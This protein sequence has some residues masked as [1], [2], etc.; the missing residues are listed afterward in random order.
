MGPGT[1]F[2][3]GS[4]DS[5]ASSL[6]CDVMV[7]MFVC[8]WDQLL[9]LC[10]RRLPCTC[11]VLRRSQ[12]RLPL[13]VGEHRIVLFADVHPCCRR[14]SPFWPED[15]SIHLITTFFF[16]L[17]RYHYRL[18]GGWSQHAAVRPLC[19]GSD[20]LNAAAPYVLILGGAVLGRFGSLCVCQKIALLV[21]RG[22]LPGLALCECLL[23]DA[24]R[25]SA[26]PLHSTTPCSRIHRVKMVWCHNLLLMYAAQ[27]QP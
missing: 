7:W 22:S 27:R 19:G 16:R 21:D 25:R 6:A 9:S 5:F 10:W 15:V 18:W 4:D 8:F 14:T 2:F 3:S 1:L 20:G 24:R 26:P 17:Q 13:K 12:G 11:C 23:P